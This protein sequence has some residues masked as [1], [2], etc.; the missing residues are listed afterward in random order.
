MNLNVVTA[1]SNSVGKAILQKV[2]TPQDITLWLSRK[3]CNFPHV[4]DVGIRFN[5]LRGGQKIVV[6]NIKINQSPGY[7]SD[8]NIS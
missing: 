3:W 8:K 4:M 5:W 6:V 1:S 7:W 2:A